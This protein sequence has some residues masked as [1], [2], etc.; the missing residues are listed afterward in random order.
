MKFQDMLDAKEKM[1]D[2]QREML[3]QQRKQI[4]ETQVIPK[5]EVQLKVSEME[6][7]HEMDPKKRYQVLEF[8]VQ[9]LMGVKV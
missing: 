7:V 2:R 1:I 8:L 3:L 5:D 4:M 6:N 9:E